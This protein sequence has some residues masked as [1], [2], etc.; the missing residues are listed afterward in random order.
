MED[1]QRPARPQE[2]HVRPQQ[3]KQAQP[4]Q[5]A[6]TLRE[7]LR[8]PGPVHFA[9]TRT[10]EPGIVRVEIEGELDVLTTPRLATEL[11]SLV[12]QSNDD[13]VVDLRRT[14][15]IDSAGLQILLGTQRRLGRFSRSLTVVCDDGPVRRVIELTRL[16]EAFGL[17]RGR[18]EPG[19]N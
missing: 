13:I 8:P 15:F 2:G 17:T 7:A 10:T 14:E 11:N 6:Q 5:E 4:H 3:E 9:I 18:E 19:S 12:R 16:E 1:R